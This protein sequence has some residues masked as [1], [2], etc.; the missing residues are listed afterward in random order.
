MSIVCATALLSV[1]GIAQ[2]PKPNS[3]VRVVSCVAQKVL[4]PELQSAFIFNGKVGF[5]IFVGG[6][7]FTNQQNDKLTTVVLFSRDGLRAIVSS[8]TS[9]ASKDIH[10]KPFFDQLEERQGHWSTVDGSGGPG[11]ANTTAQFVEKLVQQTPLSTTTVQAVS[12][13]QCVVDEP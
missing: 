7:P 4:K 2:A 6:I 3:A 8:V 1:Q 9:A 10:V 12:E 11:T 13:S 5:R